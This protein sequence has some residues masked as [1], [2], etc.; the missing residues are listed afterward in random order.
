MSN[1][2]G[3]EFVRTLYTN[4]MIYNTEARA[5]KSGTLVTE[6]EYICAVNQD[7]G[8]IDRIVDL[9]M[10][11]LC[12]GLVD[13]HT[14]GRAGGDFVSAD[15]DTLMKMTS[16]YLSSGV[17]S[18]FPTLASAT[19]EEL[20]KAIDNIAECKKKQR[21]SIISGVHL[22]GRY[23][24]PN[25]RGA[26]AP[27]LLTKL[28]S[29]ELEEMIFRMRRIDENIHLSA[30]FEL[31]EDGSFAATA[32][33]H[34]VTMALAHTNASCEEAKIAICR[35]VTSFTHLFNAMPPLHHRDGGAVCAALNDDNVYAEI[36]CDGFHICPDMVRLTYRC[37]GKKIVLITD[38]MEA[39]GCEDGEY[40][41][42]GMPVT[43][44]DGKARTH[45]GAIAGSTLSLL[46]G[47]KNFASFANIDFG[48]ALYCA[49]A[50][51]AKSVGIYDRVGSLES[52]K[53]AD[54]LIL[55]ESLNIT[56]IVKSG[57]MTK[58]F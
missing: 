15:T 48:E 2:I 22:E 44:K 34:N 38:S 56:G 49:T 1:E 37:K 25:K 20:F 42:A 16:S 21:N 58:Q 7:S 41:I 45:D 6:N 39:T 5:F 50:S 32:R 33:K 13:V 18:I 27:H 40:S 29:G 31:D 10:S 28:D 47:V 24:N 57:E 51:P 3:G 17:T 46:D 53:L 30:A 54:M 12:P 14:H 4:A 9:H 43:V 35:G 52:G 23:L 36:I 11:H 19:P 26:H 8:N 55:D